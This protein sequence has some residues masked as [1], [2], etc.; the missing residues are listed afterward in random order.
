[1]DM[2]DQSSRRQKKAQNEFLQNLEAALKHG[3]SRH[4][5]RWLMEQGGLFDT[6]FTGNSTTFYNEG[7]RSLVLELVAAMNTVDPYEVVRLMKEGADEVVH[8]RN[9][10]RGV[11]DED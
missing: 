11:K 6:S 4:V 1:M 2:N 8:L 7:R 5:L 3:P 9:Q 10:A